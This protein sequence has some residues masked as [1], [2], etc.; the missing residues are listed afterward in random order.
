MYPRKTLDQCRGVMGWTALDTFTQQILNRQGSIQHTSDH[1]WKRG[2]GPGLRMFSCECCS[3][4]YS[5]KESK[6]AYVRDTRVPVLIINYSQK[7]K[8]GISLGAHSHMNIESVVCIHNVVLFSHKEQNH[9]IYWKMDGKCNKPDS[10]NKYHVC[11][12]IYGL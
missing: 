6:L 12:F 8:C 4:L 9:V 2:C 10:K 11:S 1:S 5:A 7:P 3:W